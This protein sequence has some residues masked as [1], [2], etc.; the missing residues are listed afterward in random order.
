MYRPKAGRPTGLSESEVHAILIY[1]HYSGY[2]CF[3]YFHKNMVLE[4]VLRSYFT[5]HEEK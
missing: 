2:K 3:A 4:G 1:Y 5:L